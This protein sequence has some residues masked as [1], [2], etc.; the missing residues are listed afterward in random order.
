MTF[1]NAIEQTDYDLLALHGVIAD[2]PSEN[3]W[4]EPQR[5]RFEDF[6]NMKNYE[7]FLHNLQN[8]QNLNIAIPHCTIGL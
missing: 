5:K 7:E 3:I 4:T 6:K 8:F 2:P 1:T